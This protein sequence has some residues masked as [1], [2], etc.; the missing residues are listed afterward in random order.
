VRKDNSDLWRY[1]TTLSSALRKENYSKY[2]PEAYINYCDAVGLLDPPDQY[3]AVDFAM[4]IEKF[5]SK[6][7]DVDAKVLSLYLIGLRQREIGELIGAPRRYVSVRLA[8]IFKKFKKFYL[9][10]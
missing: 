8:R 2:D 6:L 9:A 5:K 7:S 10:E 3:A 4:D 1:S